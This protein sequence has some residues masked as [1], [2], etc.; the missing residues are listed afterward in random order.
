MTRCPEF[1]EKFERDGNFCGLSPSAISQI[2]AYRELVDKISKHG[3]DRTLVYEHFPERA[4]REITAVRDDETRIKGLNHVVSLLKKNEKVTA[5]ELRAKVREWLKGENVCDV[6]SGSRSKKFTMVKNGAQTEPGSPE[7][8]QNEKPPLEHAFAPLHDGKPVPDPK[9]VAQIDQEQVRRQEI[10][11]AARNQ[12]AF[13]IAADLPA[14]PPEIPVWSISMCREGK[15]PGPTVYFV[16]KDS[17]GRINVCEA[18]GAP[19][20]QLSRCPVIERMKR[21]DQYDPLTGGRLI[22]PAGIRI[23]PHRDP[24]C[25]M[26]TTKQWEFIDRVIKSGE[27]ETSQEVLS[28]CL[29]RAME[30]ES[31]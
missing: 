16:E 27:S 11:E 6:S 13:T 1:Y 17:R 23:V 9:T 20:N 28:E 4:A 22:K 30:Q 31:G 14:E 3:I 18:A 29:D 8:A 19:V 21:P 2:K 26:P 25:F 5:P 12:P 7:G 15:C 10:V 24:I